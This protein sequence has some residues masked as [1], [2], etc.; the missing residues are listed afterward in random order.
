M[1]VTINGRP[2]APLDN[3]EQLMKEIVGLF[4]E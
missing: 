1:T 2:A 4:G 3:S